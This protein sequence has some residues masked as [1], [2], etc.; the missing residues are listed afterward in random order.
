M[1]SRARL[2]VQEG[3]KD[4]VALG[5][6]V[7]QLQSVSVPKTNCSTQN[8]HRPENLSPFVK[9]AVGH[10]MNCLR[11]GTEAGAGVSWRWQ[12]RTRQQALE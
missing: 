2:L 6:H 3:L 1:D 11:V 4:G 7:G 5:M 10:D 12:G 8:W 9:A